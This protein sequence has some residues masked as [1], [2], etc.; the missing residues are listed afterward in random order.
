MLALGFE[1][2][3]DECTALVRLVLAT[4]VNT[5]PERV[6]WGTEGAGVWLVCVDS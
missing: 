6:L 4:A 2:L 3:T 5:A 1:R